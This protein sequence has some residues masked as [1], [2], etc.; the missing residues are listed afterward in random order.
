MG[1]GIFLFFFMFI[2]ITHL[3]TRYFD[4]DR[5]ERHIHSLQGTMISKSWEPF[6]K[7]WFG[8]DSDRIYK[9]RFLD[10]YDN[11]HE[12]YVKT[13][14]F[15]GVYFTDDKII[16]YNDRNEHSEVFHLRKQ[17]ERLKRENELLRN[18]YS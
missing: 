17:V 12:A 4:T 6:G 11:V 16:E 1:F 18:H 8:S 10:M 15:G 9:V 5:I 2:I 3:L 13:S 14:L 7:R